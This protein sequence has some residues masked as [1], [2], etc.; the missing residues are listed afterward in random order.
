MT[1][2]SAAKGPQGE[3]KSAGKVFPGTKSDMIAV[4]S[5]EA[6]EKVKNVISNSPDNVYNLMEILSQVNGHALLEILQ[7][8]LPAGLKY[9][10]SHSF[11]DNTTG[12]GQEQE[13]A[14]IGFSLYAPTGNKLKDLVS[15][16]GNWPSVNFSAGLSHYGIKFI[17]APKDESTRAVNHLSLRNLNENVPGLILPVASQLTLG[18]T[19][20]SLCSLLVA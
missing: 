20:T 6:A 13:V 11:D 19:S 17:H 5:Q 7:Q 12:S 4:T 18:R 1:F 14:V 9:V 3:E 16:N 10:H 8:N 15:C 2:N